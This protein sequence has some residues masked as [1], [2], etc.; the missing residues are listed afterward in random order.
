MRIIF[1][2]TNPVKLVAF[3]KS[4]PEFYNQIN[5]F[6]LD[7]QLSN[8]KY[9]G[10]TLAR[11][12]NFLLP[13]AYIIAVTSHNESKFFAEQS[14]VQIKA[15]I[16]KNDIHNI[17]KAISETLADISETVNLQR[18]RHEHLSRQII[19]NKRSEA[20]K[21]SDII[22]VENSE[23]KNYISFCLLNSLTKSAK[24][25]LT[26]IESELGEKFRHFQRNG[27]VNTDYIVNFNPQT[28]T[29]STC[30]G[31]VLTVIK[32][33]AENFQEYAEGAY[34]T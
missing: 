10:V 19:L 27:L 11:K 31:H 24:L 2:S 29:I 5:I 25:T 22:F 15:F 23:Q 14:F 16:S 4:H 20:I 12:I 30:E 18:K 13:L 32:K 34:I 21:V 6:L 26:S 1:V 3:I 7:Y 17:E 28:L 9:N 33:Y 8:P